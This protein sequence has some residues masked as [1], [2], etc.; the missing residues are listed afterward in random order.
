MPEYGTDDYGWSSYS[1]DYEPIVDER[2]IDYFPQIF[3]VEDEEGNPS[4]FANFINAHESEIKKFDADLDYVLQSR[5]VDEAHS[6][7]LE[8]IGSKFGELGK[9]RGRSDEEYR[10]YL[11]GIVQSF[12]G[13][14]TKPGLKFAIGS[15]VGTDPE[16]VIIDE[17]FQNNE[18]GVRIDDTDVGFLSSVVDDVAELAD[19]SGVE[20]SS[21]PVVTLEGANVKIDATETKVISSASGLGTDEI[22]LDGS[23]KLQ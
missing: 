8:K 15:A 1:G 2:I 21:T 13:R 3:K 4:V 17:D 20:L 11:K 9:R 16:N 14:G 5:H 12:R 7:D 19:P 6:S 23:W 18:Y 22:T 10:A